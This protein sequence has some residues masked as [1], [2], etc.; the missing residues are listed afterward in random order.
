[1]T[2]GRNFRNMIVIVIT[3]YSLHKDI[4]TNIIRFLETGNKTIDQIQNI[5]YPKKTKNISK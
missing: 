5:F 1:M 2:P 3:L 4:D